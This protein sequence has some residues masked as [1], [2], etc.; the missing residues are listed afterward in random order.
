MEKKNKTVDFYFAKEKKW[1]QEI[2]LLRAIILEFPFVEE[3]K[4]GVPCYTFN[5]KNVILIHCFKDYCAVLFHKGVL[6]K[7]VHEVL[8]QQTENVQSAR[9][10][11]FTNLREV[12]GIKKILK[13]YIK[14]A[15]EIEKAGT[16]VELK[17]TSEFKMPEEFKLRLEDD[18]LLK[19]AFYS[20]TPDRQRGYLLYFS[21]AKQATTREARI[22][23]YSKQIL[24]GKGLDD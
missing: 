9:Q 8:I 14:E 4:W 21:S 23:K 12:V 7:D 1:T 6:I 22:A 24:K 5:E 2:E 18:S 13:V 10:I 11:R 15:I 16:K 17:K 3:L 19:K 20:L